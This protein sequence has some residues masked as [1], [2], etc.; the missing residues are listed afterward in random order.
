MINQ[1]YPEKNENCLLSEDDQSLLRRLLQFTKYHL[2]WF[3]ILFFIF[4]IIIYSFIIIYLYDYFYIQPKL[5][6]SSHAEP[7]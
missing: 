6:N 1:S 2:F 4:F 5:L 7:S 3:R